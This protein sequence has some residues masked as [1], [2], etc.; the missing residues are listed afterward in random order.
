MA[1]LG[2]IAALILVMLLIPVWVQVT[3]DEDLRISAGALWFSAGVFPK[4]QPKK[5]KAEKPSVSPGKKKEKKPPAWNLQDVPDLLHLLGQCITPVRKL[6][7]RTTIAVISMRLVI[8]KGEAAKTAIAFGRANTAVY[9]TLAAADRL[10]RLRVKQ[11]DIFPDFCSEEGSCS[12]TYKIS[13]LPL[14]A[15]AA[16]A[17]IGIKTL[18]F[19]F[20]TNRQDKVQSGKGR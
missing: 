6:L 5:Q 11:L 3:Y 14:A 15:L 13:V 4:K 20:Q 8:A 2:W 1:V 10:F 7:K 9:T 19:M 16:A 18:F 17:D 12:A